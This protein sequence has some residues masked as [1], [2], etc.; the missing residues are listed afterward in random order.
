MEKHRDNK[1]ALTFVERTFNKKAFKILIG[2]I[3]GAVLGELYWEFI[4]CNSGSCP[5]TSSRLNTIIL[6][7]MMGG[8]FTYRK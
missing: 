3:I 4:G 8:W 7:T 5:L 1:K 6:F 2:V